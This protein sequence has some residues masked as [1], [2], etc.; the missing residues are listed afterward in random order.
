MR[1]F[2][3]LLIIL[4]CTNAMAAGDGHSAGH[5]SDLIAPFVNIF[6]L[7]ALL[8]WKLKDPV[9]GYFVQKSNQ[10]SEVLERASV[11]AK[12]AEMMMKMQEEKAKG[13]EKELDKINKDAE[14]NI[15]KFKTDYALEV[16]ERI[17]KLKEDA[18]QKI[19][20]E[21]KQMIDQVNGILLDEVINK[22]KTLI[23]NDSQVNSKITNNILQDLK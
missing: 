2:I 12:E 14:S 19:E 22:S 23:K 16:E 10:V 3:L 8:V 6:I 4:T 18:V 17:K 9:R 7:V 11:K 5:V 15:I 13:L 21:K 1:S 20:T